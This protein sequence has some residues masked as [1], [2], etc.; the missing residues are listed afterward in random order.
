MILYNNPEK[1]KVVTFLRTLRIHKVGAPT[2]CATDIRK[3][4]EER[5]GIPHDMD[6]PNV[7]DF[8]IC[9]DSYDVDQQDLKVVISTRRLLSLKKKSVLVQTDA[10]YKLTWQGYPF[11]LVG[12]SDADKVFHPFAVAITKGET[13]ED[14]AFIFRAL[15]ES[16]LEWSPTLLLAD[17]SEAITNGFLSVFHHL[18]K[19]LMCF[20][21]VM[22]NVEMHLKPIIKNKGGLKL[23]EDI[24]LLQ[25]CPN[26]ETFENATKLFT[27]KWKKST[28][29]SVL[30]FLEY[31]QEQWLDTLPNWYEG[32]AL[33]HPS[34][35]YGI[36]STNSIIKKENTLRERLPVGQFLHCCVD[37]V[38]DWSERRN[39]TSVNC[40]HYAEI[41]SINTRMWTEAYQWVT[42]N[43]AVL[44]CTRGNCVQYFS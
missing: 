37:M 9:V 16:D 19:R 33:G 18:D 6:E 8:Y 23:K 11:L 43:V 28:D 40:V 32:A 36:E 42:Q 17:G 38:K 13:A 10:T 20:F 7:L 41:R 1:A 29:S 26:E 31:F 39:P 44:Q 15:Y 30:A 4:C 24:Y 35:N 3:W 12:T 34:T 14:F 22:K 25:T 27:Q 5:K 2:I 21:R